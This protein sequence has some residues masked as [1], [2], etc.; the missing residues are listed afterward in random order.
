MEILHQTVAG[1]KESCCGAFLLMVNMSNHIPDSCA[2]LRYV[3]G[4]LSVLKQSSV[5]EV[6]CGGVRD[7]LD[8]RCGDHFEMSNVGSFSRV[9]RIRLNVPCGS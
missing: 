4:L 6:M 8:E 9:V 3:V 2:T 5:R 1:G 7:E